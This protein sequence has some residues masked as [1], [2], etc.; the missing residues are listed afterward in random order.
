MSQIISKDMY[1]V[2]KSEY[3]EKESV[4]DFA[5]NSRVQKPH[6]RYLFV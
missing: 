5:M 1:C 4:F 2:R 6:A 3:V